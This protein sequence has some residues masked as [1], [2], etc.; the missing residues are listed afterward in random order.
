MSGGKRSAR[1]ALLLL[2][3]LSAGCPVGPNFVPPQPAMPDEYRDELAPAEAQ[4]FA[5]A[6][7]WDVFDDDVLRGHVDEALANNYDLLTAVYRVEA[8]QHEVGITNSQLFPQLGYQGSATRQRQQFGT[9]GSFTFNTF[10]G[11]FNLA[12]EID[13]WGRIRRATEASKAELLAQEDVRRGVVL[14]LVS[15]VAQTYFSLQE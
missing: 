15:A 12:W 3:V 7:W 10:L 4:S 9:F 11:A 1:A 13:L 14:S 6:P 8:A 2:A 5:D